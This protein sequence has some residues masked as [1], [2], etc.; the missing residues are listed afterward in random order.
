MSHSLFFGNASS[1]IGG[2]IAI[3]GGSLLL[4]H[5]SIADNNAAVA[6]G[7]IFRLAGTVTLLHTGAGF[8]HPNNCRPI[9]SVPGCFN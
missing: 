8:N 1:D 6:G 4:D 5:D 2:A 9:F 3:D 7:G